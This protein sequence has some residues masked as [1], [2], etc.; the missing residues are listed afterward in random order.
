MRGTVSLPAN[1]DPEVLERLQP[2]HLKNMC[3]RMQVH[4]NAS[5]TLVAADQAHIAA[6]IKEVRFHL[7]LFLFRQFDKLTVFIT[8]FHYYISFQVDYET[9]K[10]FNSFTEK[11]KLYASYAEQFSK[12]HHITQQ[13]SRCN[14]L[15]NQN[16]ESMEVLNNLLDIDERLP[17]F[18]WKTSDDKN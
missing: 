3:N 11:Q 8:Q 15:L 17:P 1:R 2:D 6:K 16:L 13:L 14:M 4:L 12:L 7:E 10:V 9:T 5:A 18:I